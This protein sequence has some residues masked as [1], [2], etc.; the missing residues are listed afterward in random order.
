MYNCP[1]SLLRPHIIN[2]AHNSR[3]I[4]S[5][6]MISSLNPHTNTLPDTLVTTHLEMTRRADFRPAYL[7]DSNAYRIVSMDVPDV[8]FYRFLYQA[9][10]EIWRWRD[11]LSLPDMELDAILNNPNTLV[12]VLYVGGVP[13]GY[14][15]LSRDSNNIEIAYFGLREPFIGCGYG[16]HLLSHGVA[17]AWAEGARRVW[18]HTCNL[19]GPHAIFNYQKRGFRVFKVEREP[20]P[21]TYR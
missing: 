13:A 4:N 17:R 19:D 9:V 14:I 5:F 3:W 7:H 2:V 21:E 1:E 6:T 8:A 15:E 16:K 11:R 10:G 20:M 18:V 12:D